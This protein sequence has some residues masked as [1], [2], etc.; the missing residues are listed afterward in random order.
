MVDGTL[1]SCTTT[2]PRR[3]RLIGR[4]VDGDVRRYA[5]HVGP[6]GNRTGRPAG[7]VGELD[8]E[9]CT[10]RIG[11][12]RFALQRRRLH[13]SEPASESPDLGP[14]EGIEE[15]YAERIHSYYKEVPTPNMIRR[16]FLSFF[17]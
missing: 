13:R 3:R 10:C 11:E 8:L 9:G 2:D 12:A 17:F 6:R 7:G 15:P 16:G 5:L 4:S 1:N 14:R